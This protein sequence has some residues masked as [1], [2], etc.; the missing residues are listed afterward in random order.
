ML[1]S[2]QSEIQSM[3][4]ESKLVELDESLLFSTSGLTFGRIL[5]LLE[6]SC[7]PFRNA[8]G[9]SRVVNLTG[10]II[11]KGKGFFSQVFQV[12]CEFSNTKRYECIVKV[13]A[14]NALGEEQRDNLIHAHNT[15]C[16]FYLQFRGIRSFAL[17]EIFYLEPI[18]STDGNNG[19]I[20]MESF[21][22]RADGLDFF[23]SSTSAQ[24]QPIAR[25]VANLQFYARDS[26]CKQWWSTLNKSMFL[27]TLFDTF[28][29]KYFQQLVN[30]YPEFIPLIAKLGPL[31]NKEF[32][33]YS[34]RSRPE[35]FN[36]T[37]ICHGDFQP[38]NL[39]FYTRADG[40]GVT[41]TLATIIDWQL[42]F[43]GSALFDLG[44]FVVLTMDAEIREAEAEGLFRTYY[45]ELCR[46][47]E[48]NG[49][50][51]PFSYK[52][53][54]EL[55]E[56]AQC[57]QVILLMVFMPFIKETNQ[58]L[59]I[60]EPRMQVLVTRTLKAAQHAIKL[61]EKYELQRFGKR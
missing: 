31:L 57:H 30:D 3:S 49:S 60:E 41:D 1:D 26:T 37:T 27:T 12:I 18:N 17:P 42:V 34:L 44:R 52:Q 6:D 48:N 8:K 14:L 10:D 38:N 7:P 61:M 9:D 46:L 50:K 35:E 4:I 15:E 2:L 5:R 36:A 43:C 33:H 58:L 54:F 39:M 55:F 25:A 11:S 29:P 32:G 22:G 51:V 21:V 28:I 13:P 16:S 45:N 59:G 20:I 47:H 53:G 23:R 19:L 24:G 56:L 40:S